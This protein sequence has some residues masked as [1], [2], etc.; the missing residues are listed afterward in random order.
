MPFLPSIPGSQRFRQRKSVARALCAVW[1]VTP[2]LKVAIWTYKDSVVICN[3]CV[4]QA[5]FSIEPSLKCRQANKQMSRTP[6]WFAHIYDQRIRVSLSY[7]SKSTRYRCYH[8]LW[9][10][11]KFRILEGYSQLMAFIW[12]L[13]VIS[14]PYINQMMIHQPQPF[15]YQ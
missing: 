14:F 4:Y 9:E 6:I 2:F 5:S 8:L 12:S 7:A 13:D 3:H 10:D 11:I 1:K 15:R